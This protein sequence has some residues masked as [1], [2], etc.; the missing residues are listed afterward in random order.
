MYD[1][2]SLIFIILATI[3][4]G[5]DIIVLTNVIAEIWEW[6]CRHNRGEKHEAKQAYPV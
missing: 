1:Y 4:N 6:W 2:F 5:Y 3:Y